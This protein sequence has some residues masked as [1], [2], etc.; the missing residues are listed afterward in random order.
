MNDL[1]KV[2]YDKADRPTVMGRELHKAL[3]IKTPYKKWFD[4]MCEYGFTENSDFVTMD[5]NV[6]RADGTEMPQKQYDHQLTIDMAKEICMI[7]RSDVGRK[8]RQY[9]ISVEKQWNSPEA[10]MKRALRFAD[11]TIKQ[12]EQELADVLIT[13][14]QE[15]TLR[16]EIEIKAIDLCGSGRVYSVLGT[17]LRILIIAKL[18]EAF[19]VAK[20]NLIKASQYNAAIEICRSFKPDKNTRNRIN[21]ERFLLKS[22]RQ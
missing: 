15:R 2:N 1:I 13:V 7:Q 11:N 14:E 6:R 4:R 17:T 3:E 19:G 18:C 16:N 21:N 10:T 12:L 20:T 8:Y 9:F 5:K 22:A